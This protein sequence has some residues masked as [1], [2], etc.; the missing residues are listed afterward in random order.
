MKQ[1]EILTGHRVA[2]KEEIDSLAA[3]IGRKFNP[4]RIILF[5]S[6][7]WG[8][9]DPESDVDLLV[10]MGDGPSNWDLSVEVSAAVRHSFPMDILVR[11]PQEI[12]ERISKGDFFLKRVIEKGE[13]LYERPCR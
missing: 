13:V 7:A 6:Y 11:S 2:T 4:E 1:F 5:G 10:I 12:S 9:P 8:K 3:E